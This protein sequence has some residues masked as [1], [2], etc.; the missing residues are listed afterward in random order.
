MSTQNI[1]KLTKMF[2]HSGMRTTSSAIKLGKYLDFQHKVYTFP[3][4]MFVHSVPDDLWS[5][6]A[7][8][9]FALPGGDETGHSI[10]SSQA[11]MLA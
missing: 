9:P 1:E 10:F 6:S 2:A 5:I 7:M 4:T 3:H 11:F 8:W